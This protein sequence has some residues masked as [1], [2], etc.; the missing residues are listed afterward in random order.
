MPTKIYRTVL[1]RVT[2]TLQFRGYHCGRYTL[3]L[4]T[5]A[6]ILRKYNIIEGPISKLASTS[7]SVRSGPHGLYPTVIAAARLFSP[8]PSSRFAGGERS[9][10]GAGGGGREL[11]R[12]LHENSRESG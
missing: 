11:G 6:G 3:V 7:F 8:L 10:A 9:G 2:V 1:N 4:K 5:E 12:S